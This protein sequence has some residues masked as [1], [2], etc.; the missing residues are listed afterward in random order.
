MTM[1]S[2]LNLYYSRKNLLETNIYLS[3]CYR[4][5]LSSY[6][7]L[8]YCVFG[9][10]SHQEP[11][12]CYVITQN[13]T[14]RESPR[15]AVTFSIMQYTSTIHKYICGAQTM[16]EK[17]GWWICTYQYFPN[18]LHTK[19]Y[20]YNFCDT[21]VKRVTCNKCIPKRVFK[22]WI[23]I[24]PTFFYLEGTY[25]LPKHWLLSFALC[26]IFVSSF[27][28][29]SVSETSLHFLTPIIDR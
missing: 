27:Y 23:S 2:W 16:W 12:F 28:P 20:E 11:I 21:Y 18:M 4:L 10:N 9:R 26:L 24:T 6:E 1:L 19:Y 3:S 25:T 17:C 13:K 14:I 29:P 15:E 22:H 7:I 8:S 5:G